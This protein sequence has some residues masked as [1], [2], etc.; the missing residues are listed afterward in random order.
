MA[1][2]VR[3]AVLSDYPGFAR[4]AHEVHEHHV[5][6]VPDVFRSVDVIFSEDDFSKLLQAND[7]DVLVAEFNEDIVGYAVLLH[8]RVSR[9]FHVPRTISFIDNFGVSRAHR[10]MSV[11]RLLFEACVTRAKEFGAQSLEL[12]CWEAN[13]EAIQFYESMGMTQKRRW[14]SIGL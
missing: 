5:E 6:R 10:R 2:A 14:Y 12:D 13:Q 7:S 3:M 9:N 4:V 8:R 11:G 1:V